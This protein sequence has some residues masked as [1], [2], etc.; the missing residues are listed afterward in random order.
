[1]FF[2][3]K[4]TSLIFL[5]T[6][7]VASVSLA[8]DRPA[9]SEWQTLADLSEALV[10]E[11]DTPEETLERIRADLVDWRERF[12]AAQGANGERIARLRGQIEALGPTPNP[13]N[14]DLP[15]SEEL[16]ARRAELTAELTQ[17]RAPIIAAEESYREADGLIQAI[18]N[19]I[20][21]RRADRILELG[22]SPLNPTHW[23]G[24]AE[25]LAAAGR[26]LLREA[27]SAFSTERKWRAF[28]DSLPLVLVLIVAGLFM[29]LRARLWVGLLV[30]RLRQRTRGGS[31]V[32][33]FFVSLG[34]IAVP[35]LGLE[36]LVTAVQMSGATG[37]LLGQ[38]LE[39]LTFWGAVIVVA[40]WLGDQVFSRDDRVAVAPL[41]AGKRTEARYH[42]GILGLTYA[43]QDFIVTLSG[44]GTLGPGTKAVLLFPIIVV[45]AISLFR[46]G[47]LL[48][49]LPKPEPNADG[50]IEAGFAGRMIRLAGRGCVI[51]SMVGPVMTVIGYGAAGTELVFPVISSL[52]LLGCVTVLQRVV[53]DI[54]FLV[55]GE[56]GGE[57]RGLIPV[58]V[59]FGITIA[60]LPLLALIWGA[61]VEDLSEVWAQFQ[62]GFLVGEDR[63]SLYDF[64]TFVVVFA[65][66]YTLTRLI[67]SGLR[68]SVL[69]KTRLD[70][71]VQTAI[72]SGISYVGIFL[73]G[74]L[75]ISSAGIDLTA[76]GYVA[77]A[78]SVGI[79]F[80]L[81]NIVS[82]FVS[83][84]ILLIERPIS[85]GDWIEVGG[86]MGY[87]RDISVRA[88]R[89]ETFDRSDV[90]VPN[91][92]FISG[93]VTNY[94]RG[95]TIG[96]V[97]APVG[98]AYGT[99]TKRVE[100][101]LLEI[102]RAHPMVLAD[103][104]PNV[105]FRG[106]GADSLDFEIRAILRDV[107]W[108]M[109]VHSDIN[110]EIARRFTEEGIEIP[111]AQ[112]DLWLRNPETLRPP[113]TG[114]P[115]EG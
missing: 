104:A 16:A 53:F 49:S 102:A 44:V 43:A 5:F 99:D 54:Y 87:V 71:G 110:H 30:T 47:R 15:E 46:I 37:P 32:W 63:I 18:D 98:V 41:E 59:G 74:L 66:G 112:R 69:P 72:L 1:M 40:W 108:V 65:I 67:Q 57:Q 14:G 81:Q 107:N 85:K 52:F 3:L 11:G 62:E 92:D 101:I 36:L 105:V 48:M 84:I 60:S 28:T 20:R 21:A 100:K 114:T 6:L 96:R 83:G 70:A 91:S 51:V 34:E 38:L 58:L 79:G 24:T 115:S 29:I 61:R 103:P 8:Q 86:Q 77:G 9:L 13:D 94:T 76:F 64:L 73:A 111:F 17:I 19:Q 80:G 10:A 68:S 35:L 50:E 113:E 90:I 88:T 56:I 89:I 55:T 39:R 25:D 106:F 27:A 109:S 22:P 97:I 82:N 95:N 23:G 78:L 2:K 45:A 31:G 75:A 26:E 7:L 4:L 42:A 93:T 12:L 33:S